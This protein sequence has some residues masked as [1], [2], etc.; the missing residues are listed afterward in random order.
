MAYGQ[1]GKVFVAVANYWPAGNIQ[2]WFIDSPKS[3]SRN[4]WQPWQPWQPP[5]GLG[6]YQLQYFGLV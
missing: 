6:A 4:T 5:G 3:E 1:V 2:A